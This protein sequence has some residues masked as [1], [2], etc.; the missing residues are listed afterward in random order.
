MRIKVNSI[1]TLENRSQYVVLNQ[2]NY[3]GKQYFLV[4]GLDEKREVIPSNV[5]ILEEYMSGFETYVSIVVDSELITVLTRM[6]KAQ[7]ETT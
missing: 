4:M 3:Q 5:V 2:T 7:V 6:F 1:I